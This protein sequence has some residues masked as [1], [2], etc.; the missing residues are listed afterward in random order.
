MLV[1]YVW[2]N[3]DHVF[4]AAQTFDSKFIGMQLLF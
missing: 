3:V 2:F 4:N 1:L